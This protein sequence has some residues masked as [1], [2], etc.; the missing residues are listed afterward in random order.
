MPVAVRS[1][2]MERGDWSCQAGRRGETICSYFAEPLA[3]N[4]RIGLPLLLTARATPAPDAENCAEIMWPRAD[5]P[6]GEHRPT[7]QILQFAAKSVGLDVGPIDGVL[8]PRTNRALAQLMGREIEAGSPPTVGEVL[9]ALGWEAM[10]QYSAENDNGKACVAI[11]IS[12][13]TTPRTAAPAPEPSAPDEPEFRRPP[14]RVPSIS[15]G[16]DLGRSI[17]RDRGRGRSISRERSRGRANRERRR[18]VPREEI[19]R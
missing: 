15:F 18:R 10:T 12:R 8:G 6:I 16:L 7:V 9:A 11:D 17:F 3:A 5:L 19:R 14:R 13:R 4:D 2:N 1:S